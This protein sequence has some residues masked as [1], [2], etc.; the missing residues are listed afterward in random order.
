V[1][2]YNFDTPSAFDFH[3]LISAIRGQSETTLLGYD[4]VKH[5]SIPDCHAYDPNADFIII[6]GI[7]LYNDEYLRDLIS[8]KI[9]V[10]TDLDAV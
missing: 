4:Y 1:S 10:H 8:T 7:M 3:P 2:E 5:C 6:E 9:F